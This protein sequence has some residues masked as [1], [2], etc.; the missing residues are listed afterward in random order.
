M[1]TTILLS[2]LSLLLISCSIN[3]FTDGD[4][5]VYDITETDTIVITCDEGDGSVERLHIS[6]GS[7]DISPEISVSVYDLYPNDS[8]TPIFTD[9][10]MGGSSSTL[11]QKWNSDSLVIVLES[12]NSERESTGDLLI[13]YEFSGS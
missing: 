9:I 11:I 12:E 2:A 3:E 10:I 5:L 8:S 13:D 1:K 7:N 4:S 6:L